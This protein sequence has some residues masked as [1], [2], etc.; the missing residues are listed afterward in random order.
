MG[1]YLNPNVFHVYRML[2]GIFS[3]QSQVYVSDVID[4][5]VEQKSTYLTIVY[6][7]VGAGFFLMMMMMT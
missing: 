6:L 4:T 2:R 1:L 3:L 5:E 7:C